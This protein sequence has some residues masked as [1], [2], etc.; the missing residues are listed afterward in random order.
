ML[1]PL[2][3]PVQALEGDRA[4]PRKA[5][6]KVVQLSGALITCT[7]GPD[8]I[9]ETLGDAVSS[10]QAIP[11]LLRPDHVVRI[12]QHLQ[13]VRCHVALHADLHAEGAYSCQRLHGGADHD[14]EVAV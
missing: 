12:L 8:H 6:E 3:P 11:A 14:L 5:K 9:A 4:L 7:V 10:S 13:R 2:W 1:A